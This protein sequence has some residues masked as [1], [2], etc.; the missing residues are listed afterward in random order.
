MTNNNTN[1]SQDPFLVIKPGK[2]WNNLDLGELW[3]YR[4][5]LWFHVWREVKGKYRQM[6]L[7]PIWI[8]L[9]P[10]I[11]MVVLSFIFGRI[12]KLSSDGIP[13]ILMVYVAMIPWTMFSNA[14]S[15]SV[16]S[17][18]S[19]MGVISKVYFPRMIIP[20]STIL[21]GLVDFIISFI[22]FLIIML[23]M[24]FVPDWHFIFVPFYLL[25]A[26]AS[27]LAV[28]LWTASLTVQFRDMRLIVQYGVQV[29]MYMTPVAYATSEVARNTPQWLWLFKL[30]PM[31]WVVDG[32]RWS[33]F[34]TG[35]PPEPYMAISVGIVI[36]GLV[37]GAYV[38]R[39]TERTIVDLL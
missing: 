19:Q 22:L 37:S 23:A 6:A 26:S 24:G 33:I 30:N 5:L 7:G 32:F 35:T 9:Q 4:D 11:H 34:G 38:F 17:L 1:S 15:L 3:E 20:L 25:L 31:F 13:Y 10:F 14:C 2:G 16:N 39:R 27:A 21:S 12:A 18:V 8:V 29:F 28:G 36:L